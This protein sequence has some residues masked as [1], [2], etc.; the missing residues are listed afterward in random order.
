MLIHGVE[1][2]AAAGEASAAVLARRLRLVCW[3]VLAVMP[4][5]ALADS[6]WVGPAAGAL[7]TNELLQAAFLAAVLA[8]SYRA[9]ALCAPHRL[10]LAVVAMLCLMAA[11]SGVIAGD[12]LMP[13]LLLCGL[14]LGA[15][16]V[17]PWG[18]R[19]QLW[20]VA[21]AAVAVGAH[22]LWLPAP[23]S[24]LPPSVVLGAV[25][26][27][28]VSALIAWEMERSRAALARRDRELHEQLRRQDAWIEAVPVTLHRTVLYGD[29]AG[30]M[31]LSGN[32]ERLTGF[33]AVRFAEP[34][35]VAFWAQR[36]HPDDRGVFTAA[37]ADLAREHS[38][39]NEY[40]WQHA[41]GLY[42]WLLS[43]A[44]LL[45][46]DQG[47]PGEVIGSLLDLTERKQAE[48]EL[49]ESEHRHRLV[50]QVTNDAIWDW[51]LRSDAVFW[52]EAVQFLFGYAADQVG[53]DCTWWMDRVHPDDRPRIADGIE[54]VIRAGRDWRAGYRF[55][56]RDGSYAL[57]EDRARVVRDDLG[58]AVR[59]IGAM[60]DV[61]MR[62]QAEDKL[63]RSEVL[64]RSLIEKGSDLFGVINPDG[65]MRYV[66][67]SHQHVLGYHPDELV[68]RAAVDFV[69]PD[70][71]ASM[72]ARLGG[73]VG[74]APIEFRFQHAD[75][76]WR[77]VES[78]ID[79]W[80]ADPDIGGVVTNSRDV[81]D[82]KRAEVEL[83]R[84]KDAAEA[85]S[86]VKSEF[87]AN[88]SHEIRTPMNAILGMTEL[89]LDTEL[90]GEQREH[91][92]TVR[93]AG[94]WLLTLINDLLDF[95]KLEAGKVVLDLSEFRLAAMLQETL[96]MLAPRAREKGLALTCSIDPAV[97][98]VVVGDPGRLR[99]VLVNLIGNAI[100]FAERGGVALNV[101]CPPPRNDGEVDLQ[102]RVRDTGIGI[103]ADQHAAIFDPF[104]QADSSASR[105]Y[106]GTGLGLAIAK[107][108]V[109]LMGGTI[110]V[111]SEVGHG[112]TF[113]FNARLWRAGR[114]AQRTQG[115]ALVTATPSSLAGRVLRVLLVEDNPVNQ[116][117]A[118]RL[119]QKHGHDVS[120]AG[121][122]REALRTLAREVF[123]VVFMDVQMPEMDGLEAT[124]AVRTLEAEGGMVQPH[125]P[126]IAMTAHALAGDRERC[127][128]A[129]MDDY[130]SKPIRAEHLLAAMERVLAAGDGDVVMSGVA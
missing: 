37:S 124:A 33:P 84:A 101:G 15:A 46:D 114:G 61:T 128:A 9:P 4:L 96:R 126:I 49:R 109:G 13:P 8:L 115:A 20:T 75:G 66:S 91:L 127:L 71:L 120:V 59:I 35:G 34:D 125:V 108:L 76:T 25:T 129:G 97:P 80:S 47:R 90:S 82:R 68:G 86:R 48:E 17:F 11:V 62:R 16:I 72:V 6:T 107:Q 50:T 111:E 2:A 69:H 99:Q 36:V 51:D 57:V 122:G 38:A 64:F 12:A 22:V 24:A 5:Y 93:A 89:A 45:I 1:P 118:M 104:E 40:R 29:Q 23:P 113:S 130:V 78:R 73:V 21:M 63:R 41:D 32:V 52:N 123:D 55:L 56:C 26:G 83:Q 42:R 54:A 85:A 88:M 19:A 27:L 119:L 98:D 77:T 18:V 94:N 87:V 70:D 95:S 116:H 39:R 31:W 65:T 102:V 14:A 3:V 92:E 121:N 105:K 81:T 58:R 79:D 117:L 44:V 30:R 100:K 103:A 67:P 28:A 53:P 43:E 112:S 74:D 110:G 106:G 60:T 7:I 10:A